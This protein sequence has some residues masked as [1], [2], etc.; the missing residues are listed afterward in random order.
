MTWI[1]ALLIIAG[2]ALLIVEVVFIPG[3]TV[4]GLLGLIFL[5]AGVS[6]SYSHYGPETGF[7][8][9]LLSLLAFAFAL[10]WSFRKGAWKKF[11]LNQSIESRVNEGITQVLK[12]GME[13]VAVSALR[14][15]GSAEFEGKIFEVTT[16]GDYLAAGSRIRIVEIQGST[17]IVEPVT[18]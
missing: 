12:A 5:V 3:T 1:I 15:A 9:L 8:I 13:G 18:A 14:P 17:I 7:Y 4:V 16:H 6:F 10:Y 11:S 2:I